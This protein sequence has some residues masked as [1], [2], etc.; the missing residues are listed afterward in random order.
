MLSRSD[1]ACVLYGSDIQTSEKTALKSMEPAIIHTLLNHSFTPR[2]MWTVSA[3]PGPRA[4][5]LYAFDEMEPRVLAEIQ[6]DK[7][8]F[9]SEADLIA[10]INKNIRQ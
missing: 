4:L 10:L 2:P 3:N 7:I 9:L 8:G 1:S 5:Q 6:A